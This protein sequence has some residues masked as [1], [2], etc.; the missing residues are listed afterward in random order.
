MENNMFIP[1]V[2]LIVWGPAWQAP[3]AAALKQPTNTVA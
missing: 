2:G 3:M 1:K